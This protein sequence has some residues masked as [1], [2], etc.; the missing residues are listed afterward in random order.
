M[1]LGSSLAWTFARFGV[2]GLKILRLACSAVAITFL[3]AAVAETCASLNI[4]LGVMILLAVGLTP[5]M[6]FRPQLFTCAML[7]M[8]IWLLT[9]DNYG[10]RAP[11]WLLIPMLA[12]WA[13]LHS[14]FVIGLAALGVYIMIVAAEDI[15]AR[16]RFNRSARIAAIGAAAAFA[17]LL[18]PFGPATWESTMHPVWRPAM[19]GQITEWQSLVSGMATVWHLRG[20]VV[21]FDAVLVIRFGAC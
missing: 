7:G 19:L 16:S 1:A 10:R 9:R 3:A 2:I 12:L 6:Q 13:N 5:E 4:Q 14:G 15:Y 8:T 20:F 21:L 17:T 11:L 18:T